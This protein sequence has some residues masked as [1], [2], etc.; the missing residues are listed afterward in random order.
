MVDAFTVSRLFQ[1]KF[2]V[3]LEPTMRRTQSCYVVGAQ[4]IKN[5]TLWRNISTYLEFP[6]IGIQ[7][8]PVFQCLEYLQPAFQP[9]VSFREIDL[10]V[11]L[12]TN[13]YPN[14]RILR[15]YTKTLFFKVSK[16]YNTRLS[17]FLR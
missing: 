14:R 12:S 4:Y 6:I 8:R 3:S 5:P 9:H 17:R 13:S 1:L 16:T 7:V 2:A 10:A 15:A 11:S